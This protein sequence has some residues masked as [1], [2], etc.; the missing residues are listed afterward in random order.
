MLEAEPTIIFPIRYQAWLF[1]KAYQTGSEC[2]QTHMYKWI[3]TDIMK[4]YNIEKLTIQQRY[5]RFAD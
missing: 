4:T 5:N 3:N 2:N 1:E